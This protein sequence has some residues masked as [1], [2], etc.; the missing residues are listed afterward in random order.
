M[1]PGGALVG[2][3]VMVTRPPRQA[4][5]LCRAIEAAGGR[6]VTLPAVEIAGPGDPAAA[7]RQLGRVAEYDWVI[8][9]SRNAVAEAVPWLGA[10]LAQ[11]APRVAAVGRG[12]ATA[13]ARLGCE[14]A[15]VPARGGG[16]EAL[17]EHPA[18]RSLRGRAV[19]IVRGEGGRELLARALAARGARVDYAEVYRR[20]RPCPTR[21]QLEALLAG[22]VPEV[23]TATSGALLENL[24]AMFP[25]GR[26]RDSLR[27]AQLVVVSGRMI[28]LARRL[29]FRRPPLL[30]D[31]PSDDA[32]VAAIVRWRKGGPDPGGS[33]GPGAG[34][35]V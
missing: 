21:Q 12:T 26:L 28:K 1:T 30:A 29:G 20:R 14:A 34:P 35:R 18:L 32:L 25:A 6:P 13:L 2:L 17:L 27:A 3:R 5:G 15:V 10:P 9:V 31:A 24:V 23:V 7:R 16:S 4:E 19:L 11:L 8:F 22:G 33:P